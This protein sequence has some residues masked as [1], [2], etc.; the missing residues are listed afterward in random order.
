MATSSGETWKSIPVNPGLEAVL[1]ACRGT[2]RSL[3]RRD[4]LDETVQLRGLEGLLHVSLRAHLQAA[5][6]VFFLALGGYDD[7]GDGL[8]GWLLLHPLQELE[9]VHHGHV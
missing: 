1:L 2:G 3:G 4:L 9:T 8:V 6:G 5:D 7:D